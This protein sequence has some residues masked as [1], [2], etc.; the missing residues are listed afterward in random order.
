MKKWEACLVS[1][2]V[3]GMVI[4]VLF[5]IFWGNDIRTGEADSDTDVIYIW[6]A[7]P[8]NAGPADVIENFNREFASKGIR[9]EY[10]YY[11]NNQT[12]NKNLETALQTGRDI[13]VYFTYDLTSLYNRALAGLAI[14]LSDYLRQDDIDLKEYYNTDVTDY[15]IDGKAYGI[16]TKIDQYGIVINKDMFEQAGIDIPESWDY[17]EFRTIAKKLTH[18]ENGKKVYGMF[19]CTQQNLGWALDFILPCSIGTNSL[20]DEETN[21]SNFLSPEMVQMV[22]MMNG[23]MNEDGSAPNHEESVTQKLTQETL[24]LTEQCAMTIGPWIIRDI[25]NVAE[26]PHDFITAFVPYPVADKDKDAYSCGGLG[27]FLSINPNS[28]NK[29]ASWQFI[30]WY[31]TKGILPMVTGGGR[32]PAYKGFDTEEIMSCLMQD[33]GNTLDEE[34]VRRVLVESKDNYAAFSITPETSE[35]YG[36]GKEEMEQIFLQK[37]TVQQ[38]LTDAKRRGDELLSRPKNSDDIQKYERKK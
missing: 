24:F 18:E 34:S 6:G 22:E 28:S 29:D 32:I 26:Y 8:E 1:L 2:A 3:V 27:D 30:R 10:C 13:D 9:A 33:A 20:I 21:T 7:V 4:L 15:Y 16:P 23:M 38:G 25:K 31:T 35:L 19:F 12:G 36:I 14:D 5:G 11:S 37:K 17:D